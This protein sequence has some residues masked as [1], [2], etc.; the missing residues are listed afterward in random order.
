MIEHLHKVEDV[1]LKKSEIL[2]NAQH[3]GIKG[4]AR[5]IFIKEFLQDHLSEKLSIGTG[6]IID[7]NST[8]IS[9]KLRLMS[10]STSIRKGEIYIDIE[11]EYKS[12]KYQVQDPF[13]I[14][15]EGILSVEE[16]PK[17]K[18]KIKSPLDLKQIRRLLPEI[19]QKTSE[20]KHTDN[21]K[22]QI[23]IVIY[24]NDYPKLNFYGDA[25]FF[26]IESVVAALEIK[27]ILDDAVLDKYITTTRAINVLHPSKKLF[28]WTPDTNLDHQNPK[29]MNYLV[30]YKT[31]I[32][33]ERIHERIKNEPDNAISGIFILGEGCVY[34]NIFLSDKNTKGQCEIVL[35]RDVCSLAILFLLIT[36]IASENVSYI[37]R[38]ENYFKL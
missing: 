9:Y 26:L 3:N 2:N 23:D 22:P 31:K 12:L 30:A 32:P 24:K 25:N 35:E 28:M 34:K 33:I 18:D 5:E 8:N 13:G 29:T 19:L 16:F 6:H 21:M 27:S 1:L 10:Q 20:L 36:K 37:F 14:T 17:L 38:P 4:T 11:E 15:Q 7:C